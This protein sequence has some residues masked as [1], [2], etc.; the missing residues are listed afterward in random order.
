M[1]LY[2]PQLV[3]HIRDSFQGSTQVSVRTSIEELII[4]VSLALPFALIVNEAVTNAFKYAFPNRKNGEV[5][6]AFGKIKE[7]IRLE[8]A[9][10]G[11][12]MDNQAKT[13]KTRGTGLKLMRG[14]CEDIDAKIIFKNASGTRI[15]ILCNN[16]RQQ[17]EINLDMALDHLPDLDMN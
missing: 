6:I 13:K 4:D 16:D 8:I 1:G 9:D 2:L 17:E 10:N 5:Y 14:L 3:G 15:I 11:K 12:G 7:H